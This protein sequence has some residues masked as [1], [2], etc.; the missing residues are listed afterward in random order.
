MHKKV[1]QIGTLT[2]FNWTRL[3]ITGQVFCIAS[4]F[5]AETKSSSRRKWHGTAHTLVFVQE[6]W[7][8]VPYNKIFKTS[9]H[10]LTPL[11]LQY[12]AHYKKDEIAVWLTIIHCRITRFLDATKNS[13]DERKP[14]LMNKLNMQNYHLYFFTSVDSCSS[15]QIQQFQAFSAKFSWRNRLLL[16]F[17]QFIFLGTIMKFLNSQ[18]KQSISKTVKYCFVRYCGNDSR[19]NTNA[20]RRF[21]DYTKKVNLGQFLTFFNCKDCQVLIYSRDIGIF[22]YGFFDIPHSL[23]ISRSDVHQAYMHLEFNYFWWFCVD[24]FRSSK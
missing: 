12:T 2:P 16:S 22:S 23:C 9:S 18:F 8:S 4:T 24:R 21:V 14:G 3:T 1:S 6:T 5:I 19:I 17:Q 7:S 13:D 20:A 10:N 11:D 15:L